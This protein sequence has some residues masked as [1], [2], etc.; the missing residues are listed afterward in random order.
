MSNCKWSISISL[1]VFWAW[2]ISDLNYF[3]ESLSLAFCSGSLFFVTTV[4]PFT[5]ALDCKADDKFGKHKV[6]QCFWTLKPPDIL[7]E[8]RMV[9]VYCLWNMASHFFHPTPHLQQNRPR[10]NYFP[11]PKSY[12]YNKIP[13]VCS[14]PFVTMELL[15]LI[16]VPLAIGHAGPLWWVMTWPFYYLSLYCEAS[17]FFLALFSLGSQHSF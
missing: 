6:E 7:N 16:L 14:I 8:Y 13:D 11:V 10:C 2:Y 17:S 3:A 1:T 4:L 5:L 12:Y 9:W 15:W